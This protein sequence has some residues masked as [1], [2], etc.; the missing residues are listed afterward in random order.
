MKKLFVLVLCLAFVLSM[1]A[2]GSDPTPTTAPTTKPTTAPTT[3]PTTEPTTAPTT[4]PATTAEDLYAEIK[5]A[6]ENNEA[7][8]MAMDISFSISYE[9]GEG[10]AAV[11]TTI[12]YKM[13]VDT[14][15]ST[16]PFG[17]YALSA[18]EMGTDG[19]SMDLAVDMYIVEEDGQAVMYMQAF[20]AWSRSETGI[21]ME[22]Y[23]NSAED[24]DISTEDIWSADTKP[25]DMV[26]GEGTTM[27]NGTEVYVLHAN[28]SG[29]ITADAL[30]ELGIEMESDAAE[31]MMPVTY[32]VD[33][34]NYTVLKMEAEMTAL[35]DLLAAAMAEDLLGAGGDP[36]ALTIDFPDAVYTL[37][38]GPQEVPAVP[39]EAYDYIANN[40][41]DEEYPYEE[42]WTY[43]T[44]YPLDD[45]SFV[46]ICGEDAL[47]I[48]CLEGWEGMAFS[49]NNIYLIQTDGMNTADI[50]YLADCTEEDILESWIQSE[51]TW[52][53]LEGCY[54]GTEEGPEVEGYETVA[55]VGT[56][57]TTYIAY[58]P[59][60]D[61]YLLAYMYDIDESTDAATLLP[62]VMGN[63]TP[64]VVE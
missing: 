48:T 28:I 22:E 47:R 11:T 14:I 52:M 26:L 50:Y 64:Y 8:K 21:S 34:Q 3:A 38:Y 36:E 23:I 6:M 60:G 55:I 51:V 9:E 24:L 32:Y 19:F 61:G 30:A 49:E 41:E 20:D 35:S 56:Y 18:I 15:V 1:A 13:L 27:L 45:G 59:I 31:I 63:V 17:A 58:A 29:G 53:E 46:L 39:Q 16:D 44:A 10:D 43:D 54:I 57:M 62:Q 5:T 40:P 37:G 4:E 12:S 42:D 25:A 33:A 7:T 2:C